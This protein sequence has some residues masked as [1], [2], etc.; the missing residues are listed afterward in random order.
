MISEIITERKVGRITC[1]V[2]RFVREPAHPRKV[3]ATW[4]QQ[5]HIS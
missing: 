2:G 5:V 1:H 3:D 4:R